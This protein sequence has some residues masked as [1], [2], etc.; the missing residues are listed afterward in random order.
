M[1]TIHISFRTKLSLSFL[2][3]F[4][5]SLCNISISQSAEATFSWTPNSEPNL[6]GY[7]IYSGTSSGDYNIATDVGLPEITAENMSSTLT[8]LT[9]GVTYYFAATA[10]DTDGF[11]SNFSQEVQIA[12][13]SVISQPSLVVTG[14]KQRAE[15]IG[16]LSLLFGERSKKILP[17]EATHFSDAVDKRIWTKYGELLLR[18]Q[19]S[20]VDARL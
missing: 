4:I 6:A 1:K 17:E 2:I 20:F 13:G 9:E 14:T 19:S 3:L 16:V 11:E 15:L 12:L 5:F 18:Y 10:Y 8:G 7:K